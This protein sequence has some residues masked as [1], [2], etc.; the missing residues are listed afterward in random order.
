MVRL[1]R[2]RPL[3][4]AS[5]F[6]QFQSHNGSIVAHQPELLPRAPVHVSIPQW[7]DCGDGLEVIQRRIDASFNPTMV[8]LWPGA[9]N[10]ST[11][12]RSVSIPQWFDCGPCP[13]H[14]RA[15][16]YSLFQSHNGSIVA[17]SASTAKYSS[18]VSIP[19][20]F[21]CGLIRA[22]IQH[23]R[24]ALFQSHNG[25]IVAI[26]YP[27]LHPDLLSVSIPQWFDCGLNVLS[28]LR[29]GRPVS[30]PQWFDCGHE[31]RGGSFSLRQEFQSHNGS[32]V[33]R[34]YSHFR[35]S[36]NE[37]SIPQ[38]FDCGR[39]KRPAVGIKTNRFNPT[40]VRLWPSDDHPN[41]CAPAR[42]QSHNGSIVAAKWDLPQVLRFWFQSHNGSIV[43][44]T[45]S[46]PCTPS[47]P[48]SIPQWFD[49][50]FA[51]SFPHVP[52]FPRFNPTMVR[53]WL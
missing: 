38:W 4:S 5:V 17:V 14:S 8:R 48:V 49:C 12:G 10:A 2:L 46:G 42:F 1:W 21:D 43:A 16:L 32:I 19:Q 40:M 31:G 9:E 37:V 50:G 36:V 11:W 6:D 33:A 23:H 30:I 20:W 41:A 29:D 39:K 27:H 13:I 15:M 24:L 18:S 7:F 26:H 28:S 44:R 3:H 51:F 22:R 45:Q 34:L 47:S 25:S 53:L 35:P 52:G